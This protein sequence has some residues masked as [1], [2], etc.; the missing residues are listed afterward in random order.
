MK[1]AIFTLDGFV[2][3]YIGYT[4]GK[5]WN[6][7]ATPYFT[8]EEAI[9]LMTDYNSDTESPMF[10][11]EEHDTFYHFGTDS[12]S[13]E[14]WRGENYETDEGIKHLYGIGAYCWVWDAI[15]KGD[16]RC[17]AQQVEEFIFY[18]DTYHYWDEYD[19]RREEV[20]TNIINQLQDFNMLKEII[21]IMHN[22]NLSSETMY[23][24][25]GGILRL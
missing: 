16:I 12:Y 15:N 1:K 22:D 4:D 7:W 21:T 13:G 3:A 20:V 23:K 2:P 18:Y 10:Y 25:I 24:T 19:N 8:K 17:V 11:N 14:M 6:G 5:M 9:R